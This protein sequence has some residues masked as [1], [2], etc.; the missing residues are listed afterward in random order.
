[1]SVEGGA[2]VLEQGNDMTGITY[3]RGDFP[4]MDYEVTLEPRQRVREAG[5]ASR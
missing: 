4:T 1:M 2:V 5:A 3:T